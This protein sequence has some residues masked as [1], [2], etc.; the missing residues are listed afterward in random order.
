MHLK[1]TFNSSESSFQSSFVESNSHFNAG[2]SYNGATFFPSVSNDGVISWTNDSGLP[3]PN[4][5]NI[6]GEKGDK[7]DRGEKGLQGIQGVQGER[8]E[9]GQKGDK[10]DKGEQGIQGAQGEKGANGTP[11]T[12]RW[13]GTTLYITSASGTSSAN[14]K[15]DT[16]DKGDTGAKGADGKDGKDGADGFSPTVDVE[17]IDGGHRVTITDENGE[18]TFD[19]MDGKDG[20]GGSGV[21]SW[22]D[23]TDKPFGVEG[24]DPIVWDGNT[25]GLESIQM[26]NGT[27]YKVS[28]EPIPL[29]EFIDSVLTVKNFKGETMSGQFTEEIV[30]QWIID[31]S[32]YGVDVPENTLYQEG[33]YG[34]MYIVHNDVDCTIERDPIS[35]K[36]GV[37]ILD[38]YFISFTFPQTIKP[39][40]EKYMPTSVV[41]ESELE[42]KGYQTEAQV[43]ELINNALGVIENGSY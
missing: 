39:L 6:K 12:H 27:L 40:D 11:A 13:S 8:G 24:R 34:S 16:G 26:M 22:N 36:R 31:M 19:V 14:L 25:D 33:V 41:L 38:T 32:L 42:S 15:G 35:L 1:A 3:N 28:D 20:Q 43:T 2:A 4:P 29:N 37:Y 17:Q 10:G 5:V 7:G 23:L 18:N 30:E 21:T 9:Q